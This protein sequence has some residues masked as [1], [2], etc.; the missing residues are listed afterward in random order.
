MDLDPDMLNLCLFNQCDMIDAN[1]VLPLSRAFLKNEFYE[2]SRHLAPDALTKI[3]KIIFT[4]ERPEVESPMAT[5]FN[6]KEKPQVMLVADREKYKCLLENEFIDYPD[7]DE[8]GNQVL[9]KIE[10]NLE[11]NKNELLTIQPGEDYIKIVDEFCLKH[12]INEDKKIRL[13]RAIRDKIRQ[14][15]N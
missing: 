12:D 10:V 4:V 9:I 6:Y 2:L 11:N 5:L 15:E 8:Q 3:Q 14:N 1:S 13:I 7:F